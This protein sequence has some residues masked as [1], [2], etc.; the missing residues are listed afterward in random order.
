MPAKPI[1][2]DNI[3]GNIFG[4]FNKDFQDFLFLKVQDKA[5]ARKWVK[6]NSDELI[7]T[8]TQVLKFNNAFKALLASG[9][10]RPESIITAEWANIAFS[11]KGLQALGFTPGDLGALPPEFTA[12]MAAR[13]ANIGDAGPS[14]PAHWDGPFDPGNLPNVHAILLVAADTE[15][16]LNDHAK[17]FTTNADFAAGFTVLGTVHG[18]TRVDEVGHEHFGFKDGV[19]QPGIRGLNSPDDPLADP[20]QGHP[21]QDLLWPGEFV[22]GYSTQI[23]LVKPGHDGPNPDPGPDSSAGNVGFTNDGSFLVFRRL[24]QDVPGFHKQLGELAASNHL[25][26][27]VMGAKLVGR[28]RSGCPIESLSMQPHPPAISP[29]DPAFANP[30][31]ANSDALNNAFEFGDDPIGERCPLGAHIRKAYPRDEDTG[32]GINSES[33]TQ[34]HRLLRRGIPFGVSFGAAIG[35]G[36]NDKRGLCFLA[37]QNDLAKHFEFVQQSWVNS[38]GFP[39]V[40]AANT[41]GQDPIIAQSPNGTFQIKPGQPNINVAHFVTTTGGEYFFAPS[42]DTLKNKF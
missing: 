25:S 1:N 35:G 40:P 42:L 7:S 16:D 30:A 31:L 29:T 4:G 38:A 34:T 33:E 22:L 11:F 13:K 6:E 17:V 9:V 27:D 39:P 41:P 15:Q 24:Q 3:Q 21:G 26:V 5:K 37:Y 18:R 8:S 14:D 36:V 12:G 32:S 20:D 10:P 2:F 28:Y 23:G 19:S